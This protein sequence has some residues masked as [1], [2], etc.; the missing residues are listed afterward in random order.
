MGEQEGEGVD[1][2]SCASGQCSPSRENHIK[3]PKGG[4]VNRGKQLSGKEK[5]YK[6]QEKL[7]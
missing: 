1:K 3:A 7:Y 5:I 6:G 4:D 2:E